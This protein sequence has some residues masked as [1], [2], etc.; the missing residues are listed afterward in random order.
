MFI[1]GNGNLKFFLIKK[2]LYKGIFLIFADNFLTAIDTESTVF[3]PSL[4]F[5]FVPSNFI[6]IESISS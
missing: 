4:V 1:S 6:N 5:C 3:A 2:F